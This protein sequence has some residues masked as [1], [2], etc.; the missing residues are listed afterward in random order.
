MARHPW[1]TDSCVSHL[2]DVEVKLLLR[3]A[4]FAEKH[5]RPIPADQLLVASQ[6]EYADFVRQVIFLARLGLVRVERARPLPEDYQ[7]VVLTS[8]GTLRVVA[9]RAA[10]RTAPA[11]GA[12]SRLSSLAVKDTEAAG[13][14]TAA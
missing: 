14:P 2:E 1:A 7:C 6:L 13:P 4:D 5:D 9:E 8:R 12:R 10:A 11:P 3:V